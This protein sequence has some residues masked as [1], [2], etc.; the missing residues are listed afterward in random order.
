MLAELNFNLSLIHIIVMEV[1]NHIDTL[2]Q[3]RKCH[4]AELTI[5]IIYTIFE[6][7]IMNNIY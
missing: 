5:W 1:S 2:L 3:V 6:S 7:R 4:K